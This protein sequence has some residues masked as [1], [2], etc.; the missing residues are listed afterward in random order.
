MSNLT[1]G[2][3]NTNAVSSSMVRDLLNSGSLISLSW[4]TLVVDSFPAVVAKLNYYLSTV[5]VM[6]GGMALA[7]IIVCEPPLSRRESSG[8]AEAV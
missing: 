3:S 2:L 6:P 8:L 1:V 7:L 4:T 5:G